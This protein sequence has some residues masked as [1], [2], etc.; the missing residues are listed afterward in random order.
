MLNEFLIVIV[1]NIIDL[2]NCIHLDHIIVYVLRLYLYNVFS[3][4][5]I[6]QKITIGS[7]LEEIGGFWIR[8][9][10]PASM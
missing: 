8:Q 4:V 6:T 3:L 10:L 5:I 9:S 2:I 1:I 7:A